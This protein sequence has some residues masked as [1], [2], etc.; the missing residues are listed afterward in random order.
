MSAWVGRNNAK[1][2]NNSCAWA[3]GESVGTMG[4][5][6]SVVGAIQRR[7]YATPDSKAKLFCINALAGGVGRRQLLLNFSA[8]ALEG[9]GSDGCCKVNARCKAL[10]IKQRNL[11]MG[12]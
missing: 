5:P 10:A 2:T 9:C 1:I 11:I 8:A 3:P 12:L 4:R 6:R 7:A